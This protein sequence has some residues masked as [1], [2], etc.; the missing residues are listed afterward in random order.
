MVVNYYCLALDDDYFSY[1]EKLPDSG[2]VIKNFV[3]AY[4]EAKSITP[5]MRQSMLLQNEGSL[6]FDNWDHQLFY[7][8]FQCWTN[9]ELQAY[10]KVNALKAASAQE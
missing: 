1:L 6:D 4:R 5:D 8:L 10:V 3:T 7:L 9:E 2:G